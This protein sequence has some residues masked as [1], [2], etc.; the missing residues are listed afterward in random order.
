MN[1]E[2]YELRYIETSTIDTGTF[3]LF[4]DIEDRRT[5]LDFI[6]DN[7]KIFLLGNPGVGKTTELKYIFEEIWKDINTSQLIPIYLNIKTFRTTSTIEDLINVENWQNLPS[8][9]FIFDGLDE[10]ANIQDFI[11]ELENFILKYN[12]LKIKYVLSCRTNIYEKYLINVPEFKRVYLKYLSL[13]QIKRIFENKHGLKVSDDGI[14]NLESVLQTPFN[15]DS[16]AEYFFLNGD[17]PSTLVESMELFIESEVKKTKEKLCKRFNFTESQILSACKKVA[18]SAELMQQN[19]ISEVQLHTILGDNGISIF[20]EL[21]FIEIQESKTDFNF[22][23]KNYQEYFAAKYIEGLENEKIIDFISVEGLKK[24]KPTLFNTVT[25]LLNILEEVRFDYLKEWLIKHDI[26]ILFFA[27][28]DRLSP[29]VQ[30]QIF[31]AYYTERCLDK[32]F[33]LN[34]NGK[35]KIDVLSKYADFNFIIKEIENKE[36]L[37]RSRISLIEIISYKN[38]S[39]C[40]LEIVKDLF[41]KLIN[42]ENDY[43]K[44]EILKSIKIQN[45]YKRDSG[46]WKKILDLLMHTK[47]KSV[48]HQLIS[49]LSTIP[50]NER[51]NSIVYTIISNHFNP[52]DDRVLRGTEQLVGNIMLKTNDT[53]FFMNLVKLLFDENNTLRIDSIYSLDFKDELSIKIEQFSKEAEFKNSFLDFCFSNDVKLFSREEFLSSTLNRI[54]VSTEDMLRLLQSNKVQQNSLYVLSR[55][56]TED[57]IDEVVI[58]YTIGQLEFLNAKDIQSIRNWMSHDN[59][60]LAVYWQKKFLEVGYEFSELL[61]T[62]EQIRDYQEKYESFKNWNFEIL[63]NKEKLI[64]EIQNF[65]V[66]NEIGEIEQAEFQKI[67]W[68]WYKITGYHGLRYSVHAVIEMAFRE[69]DKLNYDFVIELLNDEYFY[70]SVIKSI[71]SHNTANYYNLSDDN[72]G[73]LKE[74]THKLER[75]IDFENV[76]D[77]HPTDKDKFSTTINYEYIKVLLFFDIKFE[78]QRSEYFYLNV[79]EYGNIAGSSGQENANFIDFIKL[80]IIDPIKLNNRVIKNI[81]EISLRYL[82]KKDHFEYAIENNLNECYTKIGQQLIEDDFLYF[83]SDIL[84]YFSDKIDNPLEYLKSCCIDVSTHLCWRAVNLIKEK[85]NDDA[86]C[87]EIA[88]TYLGKDHKEFIHKAVNI[89]FY[90]NQKDSLYYYDVMLNTM[91]DIQHGGA[92][93]NLPKDVSNYKRLNELELIEPLFYKIFVETYEGSF[94]LHHSREFLRIVI[95]NFGHCEEGYNNLKIIL[96]KIKSDVDDKT[97]QAFYINHLIEILENSYLKSNSKKLSINDVIKTINS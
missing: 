24:I 17:F 39:D 58:A 15:L 14:E 89:L 80:R 42:V 97:N 72:K 67:F 18:V 53:D 21:P 41:N 47:D 13:D 83:S 52:E 70:L 86:F 22:R 34:Q 56:F 64:S 10:I 48:S 94:Y 38:L 85:Y 37:E 16:F 36:R 46:F 31:E 95:A 96:S 69:Q 28:D 87:L 91:I 43:F 8:I 29:E 26:E 68:D 30:N 33:W 93:G 71:L 63:F 20:Q 45:I 78:I 75:K 19:S 7:D 51:N 90:T 9:I 6:Y 27:D 49:I 50:E 62:D 1:K 65:F 82:A 3:S 35:V 11:S 4:D 77:F 25:F 60:E 84:E 12:D 79:L 61:Y 32:T 74:L 88:R 54:G 44:S 55:Y 5:L 92:S 73:N 66:T 57:S 81:K 59:R 40:Q 76:I 23:H 2:Y